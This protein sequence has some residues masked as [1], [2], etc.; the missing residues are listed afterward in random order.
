MSYLCCAGCPGRRACLIRRMRGPL[1]LCCAGFRSL[2]YL[3]SGLI[4]FGVY[5]VV[6][7]WFVWEYSIIIE[8]KHLSKVFYICL[9]TNYVYLSLLLQ[10]SG[11]Y[12]IQLRKKR[13]VQ[14][15]P[16]TM[17]RWASFAAYLQVSGFHSPFSRTNHFP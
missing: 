3:Q 6:L 16:K 5:C 1:I 10:K 11:R 15:C 2:Q 8:Y 4:T 17:E 13:R 14:N 12:Q 7:T 9:F